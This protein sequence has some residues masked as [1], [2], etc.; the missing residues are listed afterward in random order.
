MANLG[1]KPCIAGRPQKTPGQIADIYARWVPD[2]EDDRPLKFIDVM[3]L[4]WHFL[5]AAVPF[6]A[7]RAIGGLWLG[8]TWI[9]WGMFLRLTFLTI[10]LLE[11]VGL[12]R[13][14]IDYK[15]KSPRV[16]TRNSRLANQPPKSTRQMFIASV[17]QQQEVFQQVS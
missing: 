1:A 14:V 9:V 8:L 2:P 15:H 3:F 6:A 4:P 13:D 11:K 12:V 7:D 16:G 5:L 17:H 10:R